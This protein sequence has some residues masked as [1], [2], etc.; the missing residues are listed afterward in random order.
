[1]LNVQFPKTVLSATLTSTQGKN[2]FDP[3]SKLMTWDVGKIDPTKLPNIKG[4]VSSLMLS[5]LFL[6]NAF[7]DLCLQQKKVLLKNNRKKSVY[8]RHDRSHP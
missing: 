7:T 1:M 2:S 6:L 4:S 5:S 3:V 8:R